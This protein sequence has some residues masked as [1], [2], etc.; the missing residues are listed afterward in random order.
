M[1]SIDNVFFQ[2]SNVYKTYADF[3][4]QSDDVAKIL[5]SQANISATGNQIEISLRKLLLE[6][7]P[8]KV[9]I[10]QGHIVD[11]KGA[12]SYQQDLILSENINSKSLFKTLDGTEFFAYESVFATC[13]VKKSWSKRTF[14]SSIRSIKHTKTNLYRKAVEP[15]RILSTGSVTITG[16]KISKYDSRNPF[17]SIAFSID[18]DKQT[19]ADTFNGFFE[20]RK[21]WKFLPNIIVVLKKGIYIVID[22]KK[23][24]SE[25]ISIKLYPE[26]EADNH[27]CCWYF[28][29]E[30]DNYGINLAMMVF[31]LMQHLDDTLLD[32]PSFLEYG[33]SMLKINSQSLSKV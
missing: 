2:L 18:Y 14:E 27:D 15:N 4:L 11:K 24:N 19:K 10:G 32:H 29:S 28:F 25:T 9:H 8:N 16:N 26:N 33:I 13:E 6:L 5:H 22:E 30:S 3:L 7:L 23:S 31:I 12:L 20:D 21:K 1:P 17:F